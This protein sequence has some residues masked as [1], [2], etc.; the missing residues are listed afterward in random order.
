MLS[1]EGVVCGP[2]SLSV[3]YDRPGHTNQSMDETPQRCG[4]VLSSRR[5]SM[6]ELQKQCKT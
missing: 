3:M 1:Q 6:F 4:L 5:S 2:V